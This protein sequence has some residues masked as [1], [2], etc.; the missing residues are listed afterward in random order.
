M[1]DRA[2][3][4]LGGL[5]RLAA[6]LP[7]GLR[8]LGAVQLLQSVSADGFSDV[9]TVG[10]V[11]HEVV[12]VVRDGTDLLLASTSDAGAALRYRPISTVTSDDRTSPANSWG[13]AEHHLRVDLVDG[14]SLQCTALFDVPGQ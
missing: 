12:A 13:P 14:V 6:E 11:E 10:L 2:P 1:P 3:P 7:A 8:A 5:Q 4:P 9:V